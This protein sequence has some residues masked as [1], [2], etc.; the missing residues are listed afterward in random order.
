[1]KCP[2]CQLEINPAAEMAR[3]RASKLP[4]SRRKEISQRALRIRWDRYRAT[5]SLKI[6]PGSTI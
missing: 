6:E 4:P 2:N 5:K 1:M 3:L